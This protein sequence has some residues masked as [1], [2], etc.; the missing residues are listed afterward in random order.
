MIPHPKG[1][2]NAAL[3]HSVPATSG[4][5]FQISEAKIMKLSNRILILC[6]TLALIAVPIA[7]SAQ[8]NKK[9]YTEWSEKDARKLLENSPWAQTQIFSDTSNEFGRGIARGALGTG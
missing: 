9:P 6:A 5:Q 8:L 1:M 3:A 4:N 2:S 7:L